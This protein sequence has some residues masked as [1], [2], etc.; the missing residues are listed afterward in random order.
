MTTPDTAI[1]STAAPVMDRCPLDG[2]PVAPFDDGF[3]VCTRC[4]EV[5]APAETVAAATP[6]TWAAYLTA[7]DTDTDPSEAPLSALTRERVT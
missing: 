5:L 2:A 1:P 4:R 7:G 6:E 3:V